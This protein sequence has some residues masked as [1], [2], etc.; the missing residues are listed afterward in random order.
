MIFIT[1][2]HH[3]LV[4]IEGIVNIWYINLVRLSLPHQSRSDC[5]QSEKGVAEGARDLPRCGGVVPEGARS[6]EEGR[7]A[8]DQRPGVVGRDFLAE[9]PG[10]PVVL[11]VCRQPVQLGLA[12]ATIGLFHHRD[13]DHHPHVPRERAVAAK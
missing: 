4:L 13:V 1:K 2:A 3:D 9:L 10:R 12:V 6:P 7:Q 11:A 5:G 8:D